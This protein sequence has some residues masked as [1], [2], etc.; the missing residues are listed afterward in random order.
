MRHAI[1]IDIGGTN[2]KSGVVR[3]DGVLEMQKNISTN[4]SEGSQ[5]LLDRIM[6]LIIEYKNL[7][8]EKKLTL[9]CIGIGTA[10]YVDRTGNIAGATLNLPGW[11]GVQLAHYI[12]RHSSLPVFVD[13][14]VN[15]IALG[16]S[17][18]GA[19]QTLNSFLCVALGTGIGGCLIVDK[20]PFRG[21]DGY[22][23]GYGHQTIIMDGQMCTCGNRGCWEQYA[24]V[25]A[26]M[27]LAREEINDKELI[28]SSPI[29]LFL[30]ARKGNTT[31]TH[32]IERYV[33]FISVGLVNLI[34]AFN[35][36]AIIIGGA[37]TE[38]GD[39]F[40]DQIRKTVQSQTIKVYTTPA[41]P[42]I[43]ASLGNIAGVLGAAKY[44]L[45]KIGS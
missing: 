29:E 4:A 25:P 43:P 17:H 44:A 24:S 8:Q 7:T 3:E 9:S 33:R 36:P 20:K 12:E 37:I 19:G 2:I 45:D 21:R 39:Y 14:D 35:P 1:A 18:F 22:A 34:H 30:S 26:L 5:A 16:E 32:I 41:I 38:Q 10:G 6:S 27:R 28:A 11:E 13:N 40:F 31:A 42:I 23:G 15:M